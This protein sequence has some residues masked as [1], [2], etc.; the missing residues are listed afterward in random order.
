M[1]KKETIMPHFQRM[2]QPDERQLK[3][4]QVPSDIDRG[5]SERVRL[6]ALRSPA[7]IQE[8]ARV[9]AVNKAEKARLRALAGH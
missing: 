9:K 1:F 3:P 8:S 4:G 6:N 2:G 5:K 7:E